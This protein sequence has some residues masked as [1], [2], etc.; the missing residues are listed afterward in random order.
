MSRRALKM[1][2]ML[3]HLGMEQLLK[4][5]EDERSYFGPA[6]CGPDEFKIHV[7]V[8]V[9]EYAATA[10]G[11]RAQVICTA[12]VA[13]FYTVKG[14]GNEELGEPGFALS[15]GSS[16]T[17]S[18]A[19]IAQMMSQGLLMGPTWTARHVRLGRR[20]KVHLSIPRG[21]NNVRRVDVVEMKGPT[22]WLL[23]DARRGVGSDSD[24]AF[25]LAVGGKWMALG[26]RLAERIA[27]GSLVLGE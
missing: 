22:P 24:A 9:A 1:P 25:Q 13:R 5:T 14:D 26:Q 4:V 23:I 19:D 6:W 18:A 3:A 16:E 12:T 15:T 11:Q 10:G 21:G 2:D 27:C 7:P 8:I 17:E 20:T